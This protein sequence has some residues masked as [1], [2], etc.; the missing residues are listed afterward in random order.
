MNH[1]RK[2]ILVVEDDPSLASWIADYLT[3]Q[4]SSISVWA[5]SCERDPLRVV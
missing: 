3:D 4:L 5:S 1:E 2:R